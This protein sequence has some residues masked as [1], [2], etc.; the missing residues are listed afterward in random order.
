[1][2][3]L[4][5][6]DK[7]L[8]K[9]ILEQSRKNIHKFTNEWTDENYHDPGITFLE[10]MSWLTEMQRYYLNIITPRNKHKFFK[11][12]DVELEQQQL[13]KT[14]VSFPKQTQ[15]KFIPKGTKLKAEEQVFQT[16]REIFIHDNQ[17]EKILTIA[18]GKVVDNTFYNQVHKKVN[19]NIFGEEPQE[20]N[21][22][23]FGFSNK[24]TQKSKIDLAFNIFEEYSVE[25]NGDNIFD[26]GIKGKWFVFSEEHKWEEA[27]ICIDT[28]RCFTKSGVI[29]MEI[30][31]VM[32]KTSISSI[33][34][35]FYWIMFEVTEVCE[36][37]SPNIE[38]VKINTVGVTNENQLVRVIDL[39]DM[40]KEIVL[41]D[42][43]SIYGENIIQFQKDEYWYDAD[44][45]QYIFETLDTGEVK[46]TLSTTFEKA[47]LL[48]YDEY[49]PYVPIIGSG[50]GLPDQVV[51]VKLN[52]V[53]LD[54]LKIQV[55]K[56]VDGKMAWVDLEYVKDFIES[57]CISRC[58]TVDEEHSHILFGN[59]ECGIIPEEFEDNIR[60]VNYVCSNKERGNVK[61]FEINEF[62]S[63]PAEWQY[64]KFMNE[65]GAV[66]G[67][68]EVDIH[69][70]KD[71]ILK[72][73]K[74]IFRAVTAED[75]ETLTKEIP[76]IR[77]SLAKAIVG[78]ENKNIVSV[79]IV[80]FTGREK[81]IP[82]DKLIRICRKYIEQYRLITT[83]VR[84]I[85]PLYVDIYVKCTIAVEKIDDFEKEELESSINE[86]LNPVKKDSIRNDYVIGSPVYISEIMKII[87]QH[88]G[89]A[90]VKRLWLDAEELDIKK[91]DKGNLYV[92][93]NG[94]IAC[95]HIFIDLGTLN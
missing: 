68:T 71:E 42:Y 72:D 29:S 22:T 57:N 6:L 95:K 39:P 76:G 94:I 85:R 41:K 40:C 87:T 67:S 51:Q 27:K 47:R 25:M 73:H 21:R 1:M 93:E 86:Y 23:Y 3:P 65:K 5:N 92:P 26:Y 80:P 24:F 91:D 28:T 49:Y 62:L 56:I 90:Y 46:L 69:K 66:G 48:S 19:Y 18:E 44:D 15:T 59:G 84:I 70:G 81:P 30:P 32:D 58:F 16:D 2:L 33:K 43:L 34:D 77:I 63:P 8:F 53:I 82:D 50:N 20:R 17:L 55:G 31:C 89:V 60:F 36:Q 7:K 38:Y 74:K 9:E 37:V 75:Y 52:D 78:K 11:L 45:E 35:N 83:E 12:Y 79:V 88:T 54:S 61:Q 4:E 13:A 14:H 64:M 10:M